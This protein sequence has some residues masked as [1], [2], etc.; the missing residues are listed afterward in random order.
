MSEFLKIRSFTQNQIHLPGNQFPE[1]IRSLD[2][3]IF[4]NLTINTSESQ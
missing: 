1:K 2:D 4:N 3:I